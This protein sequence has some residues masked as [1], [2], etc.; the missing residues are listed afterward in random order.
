MIINHNLSA[1]LSKNSLSRSS[2][3]LSKSLK[4]LGSGLRINGASDDAS[5]LSISE[6]MRG[7]IKGLDQARRNSQDGISMIQTAEGGLNE[8]HSIL[9]RMRELSIQAANDTLTQ[10]DREHLQGEIDQLM[11]EIDGIATGTTF[12]GKRLLDGSSSVLWSVDTPGAEVIVRGP[13]KSLDCMGNDIS[14]EGNF[15]VHISTKDS[16]QAEVL[17]S[18]VF[19]I[20]VGNE[21]LT[22][23]DISYFQDA[24]RPILDPAQMLRIRQ[25]GGDFVDISIDGQDTVE[26]L[27]EKLGQAMAESGGVENTS[28]VA[29][30]LATVSSGAS[31]TVESIHTETGS[32][33]SC[34]KP[35][36]E[37][38]TN[39]VPQ[40]FGSG[41]VAFASIT[42]GSTD[43]SLHINDLGASDSIQIF[44]RDGVLIAGI[45]PP[46]V[47][48][49][50]T[51]ANGFLPTAVF[52]PTGP[53][54]N[55]P[56]TD[57]AP[58][59]QVVY[60]GATVSY[61]GSDNPG[62]GNLNEYF[63]I[64]EA[65]EDLLV[66]VTG[67]G[68]FNITGSWTE[69]K[70]SPEFSDD[71]SLSAPLI[72]R[73]SVPGE[74]G[75]IEFSGSEEL[76]QALGF[77]RLQESR[78]PV[79]TVSVTDAHSG[80]TVDSGLSFAGNLLVGA[81]NPN[82]D[83]SIDP[84]TAIGRRWNDQSKL[85]IFEEREADV[86]VHLSDNTT[87]LQNGANEGEDMSIFLGDMGSKGLNLFPPKPSL[88]TR[89]AAVDTI[90]RVDQA[91]DLVSRQRGRLGAYQNRLEHSISN[92]TVSYEN[93]AASESKIRDLDMAKE[94]LSFSRANILTQAATSILQQANVSSE[95]VLQ[96]L[97]P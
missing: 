27:K 91:I 85:F 63:S 29:D 39:G 83:I 95:Q 13:L 44:T 82:I 96:L 84:S 7:Q 73:S 86:M 19:P 71:Y 61:S 66:F 92:L 14:G 9:Q 8:S 6:K 41:A 45:N 34:V 32:C 89:E 64:D 53:L 23:N 15:N 24:G 33:K 72:L 68:A 75:E 16:G 76:L 77:S 52:Q 5:G 59:N 38:L 25:G 58:Y 90:G 67:I 37:I 21:E 42:E 3:I 57:V 93:T 30:F 80:K 60:D 65:P 35:I 47:P 31:G 18:H 74:D 22:L 43:V 81:V 12:N 62:G 11:D 88:A 48:I 36:D 51:E 54:V 55:P 46:E 17:K 78:E 70:K 20:R 40:G 28:G 69:I 94:M 49:P 50:M 10:Q 4:R 97:N 56:Y 79:R 1:L 26:E 2:G 87:V